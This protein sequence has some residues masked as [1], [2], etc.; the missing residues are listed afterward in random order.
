LVMLQL[1]QVEFMVRR[2]LISRYWDTAL[3]KVG[4]FK[5]MLTGDCF[6][7]RPTWTFGTIFCFG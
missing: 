3:T 5:H 2:C 4:I 6:Y 7:L 1:R